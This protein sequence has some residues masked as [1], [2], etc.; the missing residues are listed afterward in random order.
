MQKIYHFSGSHTS[1]AVTACSDRRP[2]LLKPKLKVGKARPKPSNFTD[3]SFKAKSIVINKQSISINAPSSSNQFSH[4]VSMLRSK[5]DSQRA[6]SLAYLTNAISIRPQ[7]SSLPESI[8][9]LLP[10]VQPL[11]LDPSSNVRN[12][13]LK[14]LKCLQPGEARGH[15]EKLILYVHVGMTHLAAELRLFSIEVLEWLLG[16]APHEVVSSAGGWVKTLDCFISLLK[17]HDHT[18]QA[19]LSGWSSYG[20]SSSRPDSEKKALVRHLS[21]LRIFLEKGM[22]LAQEDVSSE[23]LHVGLRFLLIH[24]RPNLIPERANAFAR[25]NLFGE[26]SDPDHAMLEEKEDRQRIFADRYEPTFRR[27]IKQIKSEGGQLLQPADSVEKT[28]AAGLS[29]VQPLL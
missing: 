13:L 10:K 9:T 16:I 5:S 15:V 1:L 8:A 26:Q 12:R 19:S 2:S 7:R 25:I 29:D 24:V 4:H 18:K 28:M 17:W 22:L 27:G 11:L 20:G 14:F 3:T 6:E 23:G 21:A